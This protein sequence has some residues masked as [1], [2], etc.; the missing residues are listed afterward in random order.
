MTGPDSGGDYSMWTGMKELM[1]GLSVP[2]LIGAI[3]GFMN[4]LRRGG[5]LTWWQRLISL[6]TSVFVAVLTFWGLDCMDFPPTVDTAIIGG[7]AY[8]GGSFL[9]A[10]QSRTLRE[11][12]HGKS[13]IKGE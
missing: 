2:L 6:M 4:L 11:V 9:D 5:N 7:L 8:M 13:L 1:I 12:R 10:V 3:A